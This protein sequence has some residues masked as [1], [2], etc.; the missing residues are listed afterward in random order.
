MAGRILLVLLMLLAWLIV[1]LPLKAV[2]IAAGGAQRLGY[3][4]VFGTVWNGRVYGLRVQGERVREVALSVDP[5]ALFTGRLAADWRM[6]DDGL[7]AH[8][9]AVLAPGRLRIGNAALTVPLGR[10]ADAGRAGL[11]PR[12]PVFIRLARLALED[13][14]CVE[15]AG[16][17]RADALASLAARQG[18]DAPPLEGEIA[19]AG[20]DVEL[21]FSGETPDMAVQG[22]ALLR[23]TGYD[24]QVEVETSRSELADVLALA[25][26]EADGDAWRAEGHASYGS[27]S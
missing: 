15:A 9:H 25:G 6:I 22:R 23:Q 20:D 5:L 4:D 19:C 24:W 12:D 11:D 3:Q 13:G 27:D 1:L 18:V 7:S 10:I 2:A 8:G 17:V 14:R 26:F 21:A 16:T